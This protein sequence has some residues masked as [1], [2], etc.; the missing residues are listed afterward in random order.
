[1]F[2]ALLEIVLAVQWPDPNSQV[3]QPCSFL[4]PNNIPQKQ[5]YHFLF[6]SGHLYS[7]RIHGMYPYLYFSRFILSTTNIRYKRA[8][9]LIC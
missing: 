5:G 8:H 9:V 7:M 2:E 3:N 6:G 1:M 4:P